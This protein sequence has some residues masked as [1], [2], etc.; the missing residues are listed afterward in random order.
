MSSINTNY[1]NT[2]LPEE[3]GIREESA[4]NQQSAQSS[5]LSETDEEAYRALYNVFYPGEEALFEERLNAFIA[6]ISTRDEVL[7]PDQLLDKWFNLCANDALHLN[8]ME[9]YNKKDA[10]AAAIKVY[11]LLVNMI[12]VMQNLTVAQAASLDFYTALEKAYTEL[13]H[14]V[15]TFS[16]GDD[17]PL[18]KTGPITAEDYTLKN[19]WFY[20]ESLN[21]DQWWRMQERY[22][23]AQ[24][25][26]KKTPLDTAALADPKFDGVLDRPALEEETIDARN[27][28]NAWAAQTIENL[29]S[30]RSLVME[31]AK[32]KNVLI[33][34][35]IEVPK[36]HINA[37]TAIFQTIKGLKIFK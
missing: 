27:D 9:L 21:A 5:L 36:E 2:P 23:E 15:P 7:T 33:T 25:L 22:S 24:K 11:Y 4:V 19:D 32:Q 20:D 26:L 10:S 12:D 30:Q 1:S 28:A 18:G 16:P 37:L 35:S 34:A 13:M 17:S 31:E 14:S 29:R 8:L 6:A 3:S